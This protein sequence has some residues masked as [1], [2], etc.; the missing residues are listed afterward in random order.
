[1]SF[2]VGVQDGLGVAVEDPVWSCL[3]F[4]ADRAESPEAPAWWDDGPGTGGLTAVFARQGAAA[5]GEGQPAAGDVVAPWRL[6]KTASA[7]GDGLW[8]T[9]RRLAG[10][11]MG[12]NP[13]VGDRERGAPPDRVPRGC[14]RRDR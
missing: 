1:V 10:S 14:R 2:V 5:D 3:A 13:F 11:L 7:P 12:L 6:R 9:V 8:N 4:E